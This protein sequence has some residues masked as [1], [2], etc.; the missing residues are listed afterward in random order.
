MVPTIKQTYH[1]NAYLTRIQNVNCG[2]LARTHIL[3]LLEQQPLSAS[4]LAR[5]AQTNYSVVRHHL[6]LLEAEETVCRKGERPIVWM[7]TG[8]GQKRL[9]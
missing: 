6:L 7:L 4:T 9:G 2:L 8:L 5:N 1:P 3:S